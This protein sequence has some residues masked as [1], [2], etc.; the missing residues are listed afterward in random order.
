MKAPRTLL[1]RAALTTMLVGQAVM[2]AGLFVWMRNHD[3]AAW[4]TRTLVLS[5]AAP[6]AGLYFIGRGLQ[7]WARSQARKEKT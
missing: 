7:S 1:G 5:L 2:L 6:G 3:G 4:A